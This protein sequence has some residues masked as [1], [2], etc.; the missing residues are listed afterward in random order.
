MTSP[1]HQNKRL[2]QI[3]YSGLGGHS[4]VAFSLSAAAQKHQEAWLQSLIFTG[5][6]PVDDIY[7]EK[8]GQ[9]GLPYKYVPTAEGRPYLSWLTMFWTLLKQR[10]HIIVLHSVKMILPCWLYAFLFGAKLIAVEHQPNHLKTGME[11]RV[12]RLLMRLA[13]AVVLLTQDYHDKLKAA[14][15]GHWREDKVTIIPNGIDTDVFAPALGNTASSKNRVIIGMAARLSRTKRQDL[16]IEAIKLLADR[17]PETHWQLSI[18][19]D[20]ETRAD[21]ERQAEHIEGNVTI[22]FEGFLNEDDLVE[23]F[24]TLDIY[25][26]ASDGE[27][28]STSILQAMAMGLP[29]VGSNVDGIS[30]LLGADND[31]GIL[32][33]TQSGDDFADALQEANSNSDIVSKIAA[34]ARRLAVTRYSQDAMYHAYKQV[35]EQS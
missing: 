16:L 24:K 33:K 20:G 9:L 1:L 5:I 13:D 2:V 25:T 17:H 6:E 3:L 8:S 26:H 31:C 32:T 29:I 21:L 12:S 18:A 4:S 7:K 14:L 35:I 10:P 23:W 15:A 19:G 30:N 11:W 34:N 22:S 28:L 27:T